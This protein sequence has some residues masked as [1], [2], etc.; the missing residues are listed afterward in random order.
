MVKMPE[1]IKQKLRE[2]D[3]LCKQTKKVE[4]Q[5]YLEFSNYSVNPNYLIG[6]G[7]GHVKTEAFSDIVNCLGDIEENIKD[8]ERV[9]LHYTKEK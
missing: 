3:S 8:I 1:E 9:F 4:N 7:E 2:L 5:L 6:F